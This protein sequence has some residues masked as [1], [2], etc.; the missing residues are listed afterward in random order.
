MS[1]T[2]MNRVT[3]TIR[4][5]AGGCSHFARVTV[6]RDNEP[7][8]ASDDDVSPEWIKACDAGVQYALNELGSTSAVRVIEIQGT[9]A[10]TRSDTLFAASAI[11]AFR[12]LGDSRHSE[13]FIDS[14]WEVVT[15][16]S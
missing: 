9:V 7:V 3:H 10:D 16:E 6:S 15:M 14:K 1:M 2:T 8:V 11:A 5:A 4:R 13:R 12:V